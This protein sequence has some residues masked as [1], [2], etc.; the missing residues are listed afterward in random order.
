MLPNFEI[1]NFRTF[2]RLK[3]ERLGRVNLIVGKNGVGKT[4]LLEA[5]RFF[6]MGSPI[7]LRECLA[8]HDEWATPGAAG[9]AMLDLRALFH[10]RDI[11][12]DIEIGLLA[13]QNSR[14]RI[15][16]IDVER[17]EESDGSYHYEEAE[18]ES[19]TGT[20]AEILKGVVVQLR[21][22][23]ILVPPEVSRRGQSRRKYAG[24]AFV[25]AGGV[26]EA[27]LSYWWEEIVLTPSEGRILETMSLVAPVEGVA[28]AS[29][30]AATQPGARLFKARLRDMR[31]PVSL[32]SLGE[33]AVHL[34]QIAVALEFARL[35]AQDRQDSFWDDPRDLQRREM[36]R[37]LLIDEI[38]NGI[39]YG[40]QTDLWRAV[41]RLA[42]EHDLQVFATS[43]S[44][45]CVR[46]FAEA[47]AADEQN[48]GLVIRLERVEGEEQTGAVVIDRESL[49]IVVRDAIEVR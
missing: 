10:G 31:S 17:V 5:L 33:G 16:L 40:I 24:P 2:G 3:I 9:E 11:P 25:P 15:R 21:N 1:L 43:H 14:L 32:K 46:G 39:H 30:P 35:A 27:D 38:E 47:L 19:R 8:D 48:D 7:A 28:T 37:L 22:R 29:H 12:P 23:R 34:F 4:T 42:K 18:E 20:G 44:R 36:P 13:D 49:P 6:G 45:D 41:F 26:S